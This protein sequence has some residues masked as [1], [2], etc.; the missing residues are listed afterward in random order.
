MNGILD[1]FK[2]PLH[3][4]RHVAL[5]MFAT[6]E[7]LQLSDS[8]VEMPKS[9]LLWRLNRLP[10]NI[11]LRWRVPWYHST[12][13]LSLSSRLCQTIIQGVKTCSVQYIVTYSTATQSVSRMLPAIVH[14]SHLVP[15]PNYHPLHY[16]SI[17][18]AGM[19]TKVKISGGVMSGSSGARSW[20]TL[21]ARKPGAIRMKNQ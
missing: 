16:A 9:S 2:G 19:P 10:S 11:L 4:R 18:S 8:L 5:S 12:L 17:R 7:T 14:K 15:S 3:F 1:G 13:G 21:T 6:E 20:V